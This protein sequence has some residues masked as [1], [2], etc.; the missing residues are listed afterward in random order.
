MP[1]NDPSGLV[2][3]AE[4]RGED[5]AKT[6]QLML[7]YD[8]EPPSEAGSP[9]QAGEAIV[10]NVVTALSKDIAERAMPAV[11]VAK[12]RLDPMVA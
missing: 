6:T 9:E 11:R 2:V 7:G 8:P 10:A 5:T 3:L 1:A 12:R 4:L